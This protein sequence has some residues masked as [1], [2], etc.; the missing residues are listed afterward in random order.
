MAYPHRP[1]TYKKVQLVVAIVAPT[2]QVATGIRERAEREGAGARGEPRHVNDPPRQRI[3]GRQ[4]LEHNLIE[5][6][7]I[8]EINT[9]ARGT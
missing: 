9:N 5:I 3:V 6:L 7:L 1:T 4:C 8:N 2:M